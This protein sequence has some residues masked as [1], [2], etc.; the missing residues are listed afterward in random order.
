MLQGMLVKVVIKQVMK[1]IEKA[2]DK[3]IAS[4]HEKRINK[5][6]KLAHPQADFVCTDCGCNA[7]RKVNKKR[8][9]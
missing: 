2:S 9:K 7:K 4:D 1:A 6:E 8:R 3:Q 5:L